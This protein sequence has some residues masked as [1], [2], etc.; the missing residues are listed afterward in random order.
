MA[1]DYVLECMKKMGVPLTRRN[2][3]NTPISGTLRKE[4]EWTAELES[5]LPKSSGR[6][7]NEP[8]RFAPRIGAGR[9]FLV[10]GAKQ[11]VRTYIGWSTSQA[12][13][14]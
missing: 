10:R 14:G 1:V 4:D 7:P 8:F 5:M 3:W 11:L 2:T 13:C 9:D 12:C 6:N